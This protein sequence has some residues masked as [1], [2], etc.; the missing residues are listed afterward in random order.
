ME[1]GE[2]RVVGSGSVVTRVARIVAWL[3]GVALVLFVLDLL[4]VPVADWLR[5]LSKEIRAVPIQAIVGGVVLESLQTGFAAVAWLTILR[6]AFP[7]A[8]VPFRPVLASYAVGVALNGFLPANIGS[9]VMM[10]MFVT[11]IAGATFAAIFSG[12]VVQKIPFTVLSVAVYVYLFATV[13]GSLSLELGF[14]SEHPA[15]SAVLVLEAALLLVLVGRFLW[16][17]AAKLRDELKS[18]GAILGQPR[19]FAVGVAL[20]A[21]ASFLARLGIVAVF[22]AAFSIPVSFHTVLAVTGA[23]SISSSLSFTPGG[24]GVTPGVER[25]RAREHD[26]HGQR[27]GILRRPTA[28]RLSMGRPVRDR[29]RGLGL[30]LVRRPRIGQA[31]VRRR[32]GEGAR[33]QAEAT[34]SPRSPPTRPADQA[35]SE[36]DDP[37][38]LPACVAGQRTYRTSRTSATNPDDDTEA[39]RDRA[40]L[41]RSTP[42]RTIAFAPRRSSACAVPDR[43]PAR[44]SVGST[45]RLVRARAPRGEPERMR[46]PLGVPAAGIA[47]IFDHNRLSRYTSAATPG[48]VTSTTIAVTAAST[49][50]PTRRVQRA[51]RVRAISAPAEARASNGTRCCKTSAAPTRCSQRTVMRTASRRASSRYHG[52]RLL[53]RLQKSSDSTP[54]SRSGGA[55]S[56]PKSCSSVDPR[57]LIVPDS[58]RLAAYRPSAGLVVPHVIGRPT[59]TET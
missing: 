40:H 56:R 26:E 14:V 29:A 45:S 5:Q 10:L 30:R 39:T 22:L 2:T 21:V 16:H 18:G 57:P 13:P 42:A 28:D 51:S 58:S 23:N 24:V 32:G 50:I 46:D 7:D 4:G 59:P 48:I 53:R 36:R 54:S 43:S 8:R 37:T 12:F 55:S 11:L 1:T 17:R 27:D 6:A 25:R 52:S 15:L 9:L 31:V 19:R 49:A 41:G 38:T 47:P 3:G 44:R 33:A 35:L 34:G 20:P